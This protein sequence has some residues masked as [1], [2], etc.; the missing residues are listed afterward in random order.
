MENVSLNRSVDRSLNRSQEKRREDI[1][2]TEIERSESEGSSS[3]SSSS[4]PPVAAGSVTVVMD[5]ISREQAH[6]LAT[7]VHLLRPDWNERGVLKA[8]S[9]ARHL[10]SPSLLAIAAI[11][12]ADNPRNRTP[13]VIAMSGEHWVT[14]APQPQ[15]PWQLT[16]GLPPMPDEPRC[17]KHSSQRLP[18]ASCRANELAGQPE[19]EWSGKVAPPPP[20]LKSLL[21]KMTA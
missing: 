2:K 8:L 14:V 11:R 6:A 12:A 15:Q 20:E 16:Y 9:D 19:S 17:E 3:P 5:S 13:A 10:G 7:L 1:G 18:C 4:S 21:R